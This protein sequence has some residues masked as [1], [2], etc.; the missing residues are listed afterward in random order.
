MRHYL[1]FVALVLLFGVAGWWFRTH[2]SS[3]APAREVA[4]GGA[5]T[6]ELPPR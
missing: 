2:A 3:S 6:T 4:A 1:N 5:T